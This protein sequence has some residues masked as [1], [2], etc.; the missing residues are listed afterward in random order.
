MARALVRTIVKESGGQL[1]LFL[2][3]GSELALLT[4]SSDGVKIC[5]FL[6]IV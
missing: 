5:L 4:A 3:E 2:F 1:P 6:R